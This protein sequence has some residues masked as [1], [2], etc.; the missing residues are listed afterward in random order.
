MKMTTMYMYKLMYKDI[1]FG[2]HSFEYET[3]QEAILELKQLLKACLDS[4]FERRLKLPDEILEND[5]LFIK[6]ASLNLPH[7]TYELVETFHC[8]F[9][10]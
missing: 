3:E 8:P 1:I 5:T 6:F 7:T 9:E 4:R 10:E 2:T